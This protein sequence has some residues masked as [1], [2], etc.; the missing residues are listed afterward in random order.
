LEGSGAAGERDAGERT[1]AKTDLWLSGRVGRNQERAQESGEIRVVADDEEIF[2]GGAL[3]E[4]LLEILE[5]GVRSESRGVKDLRFVAGLGADEGGSLKA[6]LQGTGDNEVKLD[7]QCIQHMGEL[8]TMLFALLVEGAFLIEERVGTAK[9]G[10]GVAEDVDI[11]NQLTVYPRRG[12]RR[13][14]CD[15]LWHALGATFAWHLAE[16]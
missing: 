16:S 10:A 14:S 5:S 7:V 13:L 2:A 8:E 3:A 15:A 4:E 9:S 11:H 6:A 12:F 1:F